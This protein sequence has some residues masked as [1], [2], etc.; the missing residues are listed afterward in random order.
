MIA[1]IFIFG[2]RDACWNVHTFT[3]TATA[4]SPQVWQSREPDPPSG[5]PR[6]RRPENFRGV[7]RCGSGVGIGDWVGSQHPMTDVTFVSD[8]VR[9]VR[10]HPRE[11]LR[12]IAIECAVVAAL[13]GVYRI[14]RG[15]RKD[16]LAVAFDNAAD[17]IGM[18]SMLGLLVEDDLQRWILSHDALVTLLN[19]YYIWFHFPVAVGTLLW[20]LVW[21]PASYRPFRN[22]MTATTGLALVVHVLYPL[23]PPRLL[24]GFVD[25][26]HSH[27]PN[28]YPSDILQGAANQIAAMPS[29]HFGWAVL[30][31][32]VLIR[33]L[34]APARWL[35]ALHP[36]AMFVAILATANHW[37]LDAV[38]A[39]LL[40]ALSAAG[41]E[42]SRRILRHRN[43]HVLQS[44]TL[45]HERVS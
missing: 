28:I 38:S 41:L 21:R 30:C 2:L 14:V 8:E 4:M 42:V 26:M 24:P 12:R 20:L 22:L 45:A 27:G 6:S 16:D 31:A 11:L 32:G 18:E 39:M 33:V 44:P 3:S 1:T 35:F 23:A 5:Y 15:F 40:I 43:A 13:F 10:W 37:W 34:D 7:S 29:L 9:G 19:H 17:I 36:L 25:T